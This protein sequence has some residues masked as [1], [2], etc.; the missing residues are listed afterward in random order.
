MNKYISEFLG[1]FFLVFFGTGS[2]IINNSYNNTITHTGISLIFGLIVM[3][4]IFVFGDISGAH[5]NPA[6]S[7]GFYLLK[8][9]SFEKMGIYIIFQFLGGISS[10]LLLKS[11]FP[12]QILLGN[13][14]PSGTAIQSFVFEIILTTLLILV[15]FSVSSGSKEK[16]LFAAIAIGGTITLEALFAGPIS[17]ASMNP[18]R[19]LSPAIA[20]FNFNF[21][22]IYLTAP[23]IGSILGK[24]LYL[25]THINR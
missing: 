5:F 24:Y 22:W 8:R 6:V 2:I 13:T 21:L 10:S 3:V 18:I 17:G 1:T 9:I 15:I 19:S 12:D 11:L 14:F 23:F 25:F 20:S 4:V 7:F 16:G